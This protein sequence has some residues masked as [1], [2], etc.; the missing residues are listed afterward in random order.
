MTLFVVSGFE[1]GLRGAGLLQYHPCISARYRMTSRVL[2]T[3]TRNARESVNVLL[4]H[5][6]VVQ[7]RVRE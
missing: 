4:F 2:Q 6:F 7:H 1:I 3:T 5:H